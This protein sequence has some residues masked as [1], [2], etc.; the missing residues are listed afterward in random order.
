M[1]LTLR[2]TA[3]SLDYR[4]WLDC[5]H[6]TSC[7]VISALIDQPTTRREKR[8]TTAATYGVT[9][10]PPPL[11]CAPLLPPLSYGRVGVRE[12][13]VDRNGRL[14]CAAV[15]AGEGGLDKLRRTSA[16]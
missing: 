5:L 1:A 6:V 8:S 3:P 9:R 13:L 16:V 11:F 10:T 14:R 15:E 4:D 12:T 7:A 2:F